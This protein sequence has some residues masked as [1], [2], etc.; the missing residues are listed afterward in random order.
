M[1]QLT[2]AQQ[3]QQQRIA[4]TVAELLRNV[5]VT[6][7]QVNYTTQVAT[8]AA[9]K[10]VNVQKHT[11]AN[12]QL[13]ANVN[14]AVYANAVQRS[15]ANISSNNAANVAN[16]TAQQN[17]FVHTNCYSIVQHKNNS[18]LYLYCIYN[19]A[20]STYT[21]NNAVASKQQVA[22]LLTA[23]AASKLLYATN[24]QHN[25][26]HNVTHT[27]VVRTIAL[28]NIHS[29]HAMQQQVQFS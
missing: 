22:Q 28:H 29:I 21:I 13:F 7:A 26:T 8:A 24:L 15:A 4:N 9:H 1:Q 2:S 27:V 17:Y 19:N 12:V 3:Q 6:F 25:A 11:V 20:R 16:F 10:H 23:S 18:A 14:A 5:S